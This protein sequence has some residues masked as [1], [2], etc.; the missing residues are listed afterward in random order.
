MTPPPDQHV[1][2][3]ALR[4]ALPYWRS[5]EWKR[6]WGLLLAV[7]GLDLGQVW[8]AVRLNDWRGDFF[9]ALQDLDAQRFFVQL[10]VFVAIVCAQVIATTYSPRRWWV[11]S[12][13]TPRTGDPDAC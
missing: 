11:S 12:P 6:A 8:L 4:L 7:I 3:R 1:L 5:E 9:N 10:A 2:R 13:G